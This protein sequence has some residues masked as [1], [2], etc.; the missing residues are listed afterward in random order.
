MS[1]FTS[2]MYLYD[3]IIDLVVDD[4]SI[5]LD[6]RPMNSRKLKVHKGVNNELL[7][8]ITN[9]DRKKYNVF[10]DTLYAYI[11]SP[12]DKKRVVTKLLEHTSDVGV[13]K[14]VLTDGDLQNVGR[15]LYQMHIVKND[16]SDQTYLPLF[17]DQQ[18]NANMEIEVS[19]Q[20]VQDPVA[21]QEDLTFFQTADTDEGDAANT[22]VSNAMFGNIQKNF[23]NSQHTIAVYPTSA[24]TGQVT[25]QASCISGSPASGDLSTDWFDV[26]HIDMTA[27]TQIRHATFTVSA[28]WIRI[29]SKPTVSSATSNLTKVL[30]RN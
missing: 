30:L 8:S 4:T 27:N 28:N 7:F 12:T 29:I 19:D 23:Q 17:S 10:A 3:T 11:V 5:T 21:T 15:G 6:N 25:V 2:K 9:K 13:V 1:N 16:S 14:L 20:V 24:Y 18:G 22:F 26:K